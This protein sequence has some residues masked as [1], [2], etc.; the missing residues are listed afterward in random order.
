MLLHSLNELD[1]QLNASI[2]NQITGVKSDVIPDLRLG[3]NYPR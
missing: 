3:C 1:Y 2:Q